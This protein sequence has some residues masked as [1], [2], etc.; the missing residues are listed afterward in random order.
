MLADLAACLE[1]CCMLW[2]LN[3]PVSLKLGF[4]DTTFLQNYPCNL[5]LYVYMSSYSPHQLDLS[6]SQMDG[7]SLLL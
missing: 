7:L 6:H 4:S 2:T 5:L 3:K 1:L